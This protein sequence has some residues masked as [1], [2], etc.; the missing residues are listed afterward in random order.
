LPAGLGGSDLLAAAGYNTLV[1]NPTGKFARI[2]YPGANFGGTSFT[3]L[4]GEGNLFIIDNFSLVAG[5]HQFKF[6]GIVARQQMYMDVEAA[7]K[8]AF[9]FT[10]DKLF[11][12]ND[13]S[14]YPTSFSGNI[15]SGAASPLVWNPSVYIQDTCSSEPT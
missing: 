10:Q 7:H 14:T 5:H 3:G 11:D 13:P 1:G 6:G 4:E 9:T 15:G 8:G 12:A 2:S